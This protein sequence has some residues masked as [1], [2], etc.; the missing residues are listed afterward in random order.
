[1]RSI[2]GKRWL[3]LALCCLWALYSE[4]FTPG[5][6][7]QLP[8]WGRVRARAAAGSSRAG[9]EKEVAEER[10]PLQ[11]LNIGQMVEGRVTYMNVRGAS[12][13]YVD[14]GAEKD[15]VLEYGEM[16][17][18]FPSKL[19]P[20]RKGSKVET[21]VL[22]YDED[23][24]RLY[25]TRRSGSLSRPARLAKAEENHDP[26]PLR[27]VAESEFLDAEAGAASRLPLSV[28][29]AEDWF[30]ESKTL[31][32]LCVC[33]KLDTRAFSFRL[34]GAGITS[35]ILHRKVKRKRRERERE[36]NGKDK[37]NTRRRDC[38]PAYLL[39]VHRV[40]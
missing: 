33:T 23:L 8:R 5:Q 28:D 24:D 9:A 30:A 18:G 11:A 14:I 37:D 6:L 7:R 38:M 13:A 10:F 27:R 2:G 36:E 12:L 4:T 3:V 32:N 19:T 34:C 20:V 39:K 1:M 21:R 16:E 15:A 26:E 31:E 29:W 35:Q 17:D 22:E 40:C 25:L